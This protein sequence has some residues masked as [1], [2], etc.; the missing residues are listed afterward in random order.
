MFFTAPIIGIVIDKV[1]KTMIFTNISCILL[2]VAHSILYSLKGAN[3][4]APDDGDCN[5][6]T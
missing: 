4:K 5:K 1:G 3:N 2:C 6:C